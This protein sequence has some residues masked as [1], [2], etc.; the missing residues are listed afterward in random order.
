MSG[1]SGKETG[2]WGQQWRLGALSLPRLGQ[3]PRSLTGR[4]GV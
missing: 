2:S 3:G 4:E 1:Q